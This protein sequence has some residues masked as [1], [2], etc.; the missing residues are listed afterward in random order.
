MGCDR[1]SNLS[2]TGR[3]LIGPADDIGLHL[4]GVTEGPALVFIRQD[5]NPRG[6]LN[7]FGFFAS[8]QAK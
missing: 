1:N 8:N 2:L 7:E 4:R 6:E 3:E 5:V